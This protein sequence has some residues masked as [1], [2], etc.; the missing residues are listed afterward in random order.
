MTTV[1]DLAEQVVEYLRQ[2]R[3]LTQAEVDERT[4][5]HDMWDAPARQRFEDVTHHR[6]S[7]AAAH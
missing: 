1:T 6:H 2:H 4:R 7:P 3:T 5:L